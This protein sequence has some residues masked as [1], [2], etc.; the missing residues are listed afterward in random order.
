MSFYLNELETEILFQK[1]KHATSERIESALR[2]NGSNIKN[3]A[4]SLISEFDSKFHCYP[5]VGR[6][7]PNEVFKDFT[8]K[9]EKQPDAPKKA[10]TSKIV[11]PSSPVKAKRND[12]SKSIDFQIKPKTPSV[13]K[14]SKIVI[15]KREK[16]SPMIEITS[17]KPESTIV[18]ARKG[19]EEEKEKEK[20]KVKEAE[21]SADENV[22]GVKLSFRNNYMSYNKRLEKMAKYLEENTVPKHFLPF[23]DFSG[24]DMFS[25]E[26]VKELVLFAISEID[27]NISIEL[28]VSSNKKDE[29][30]DII[31]LINIVSNPRPKVPNDKIKEQIDYIFDIER[32]KHY[33]I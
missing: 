26:A 33:V 18:I 32:K 5:G 17:N 25:K 30:H 29:F 21:K 14:N 19:K 28:R 12:G 15:V 22:K 8:K 6:F 7:K 9:T 23:C 20:E 1:E 31:E 10:E 24:K 3:A 4:S 13:V 11:Q 16:N 2:S 27:D